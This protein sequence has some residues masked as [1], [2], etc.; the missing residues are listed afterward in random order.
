MSLFPSS[1]YLGATFFNI[2]VATAATPVTATFLFF[3]SLRL[4][5]WGRTMTHCKT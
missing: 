3:N 4:L 1:P 2:N 5:Y